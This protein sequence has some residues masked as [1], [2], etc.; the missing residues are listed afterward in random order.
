MEMPNALRAA[1]IS[2]ESN[3]SLTWLE[4]YSCIAESRPIS[5][6]GMFIFNTMYFH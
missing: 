2:P 4:N 5:S 6:D 3:D 1:F